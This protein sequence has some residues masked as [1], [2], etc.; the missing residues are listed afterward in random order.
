MPDLPEP[1]DFLRILAG[2]WLL[3]HTF[4]KL[5]HLDGAAEFFHRV[6]FRPARFFVIVTAALE[7][8]AALSLIL[9][10][11]PAIGATV[12][13]TILIVAAWAQARVNGL[14]WRWQFKGSEYMIF[15]AVVCLVAG[16]H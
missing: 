10:V 11:Y 3:P 1:I 5:R 15:W 4:A 14:S 6:G 7:A 16:F 2:A 13:A 9:D 12:A 8:V